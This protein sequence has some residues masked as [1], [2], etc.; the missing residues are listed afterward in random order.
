MLMMMPDVPMAGMN[1]A[2][3]AQMAISRAQMAAMMAQM[4]AEG[5]LQSAQL[6]PQIRLQLK[7][8]PSGDEL[9]GMTDRTVDIKPM[10]TDNQQKQTIEPDQQK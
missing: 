3:Q 2:W 1:P 10:I 6:S 5:T 8:M 9:K 7:R 4:R